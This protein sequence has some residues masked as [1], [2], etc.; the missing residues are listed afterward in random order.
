MLAGECKMAEIRTEM[1]EANGLSF[2]VDMAGDGDKLALLLHGFPEN[3][4]AWRHQ[5]ALFAE[6]GYTVW[7]PNLRGYKGSSRPTG[8]KNYSLE[9]LMD[10]VAGLID[11]SGK[12]DVT[13]VVHDWGGVIG[14]FFMMRKVRPVS[15]FI[16]LNIPHP[17]LMFDKMRTW[18]Q[19]SKSWYIFFFQIPWLPEFMLKL[20]GVKGFRRIFR[21]TAKNKDNFTNSHIDQFAKPALEP[22]ALT[23]MINYYRGLMRGGSSRRQQKHGFP[24]IEVPTLMLWGTADMALDVST[25]VDTSTQVSDLTLRYLPGVSHWIQQDAPHT[26]NRLIGAW[27]KGE[28]VPEI[29][30]TDPL[31]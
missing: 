20:G 24:V 15:R 11:V 27:L 23:A 4:Y 7:A 28:P 13:L 19:L 31:D 3:S 16:V 8:V 5:M 6:L 21:D 18:T 25:T 10:D 9:V 12:S 22:G 29:S 17:K 26:V 30:E 2:E 1:V 14:W